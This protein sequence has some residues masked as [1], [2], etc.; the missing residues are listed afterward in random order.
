MISCVLTTTKKRRFFLPQAFACYTH[1][2]YLD[3]ELIVVD[4]GEEELPIPDRTT[5]I[6]VPEGTLPAKRMN[7]G[8]EKARGEVIQKLDDDDYYAPKFLASMLI[9][10]EGKDD[11]IVGMGSFL[12]YLVKENRVVFSGP[13]M[14]AGSIMFP[15]KLWD[16]RPFNEK[17][18][19]GEDKQFIREHERALP[20]T[21]DD[22][23]ALMMVV[24]HHLG[25]LWNIHY[26][27]DVNQHFSS[28]GNWRRGIESAVERHYVPFY[29]ELARVA[30]ES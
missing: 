11:Y 4:D 9:R 20:L 24:R 1:Q 12:V 15:K 13:G 21:V 2:D 8:I 28:K 7:L 5:V 3:R 10:A 16:Q 22:N 25:H 14:F 19:L 26:S 23:P 29:K 17:V 6:R 27:R 30:Q 18:E